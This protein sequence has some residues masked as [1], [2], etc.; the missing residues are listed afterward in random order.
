[1]SRVTPESRLGHYLDGH[2][3]LTGILGVGAYG[4]VY[5]AVDIH[6]FI[7][8]AIKALSKIGLEP[9][10]R[11][12]QHREI[13]L[14][15]KAHRHP[16]IVSL[17]E[18]LHAPDCIYVVMEYCAEGDLFAAITDHGHY[19]G[20]DEL[21]KSVF[22]QLL[23][24]VEFCHSQ[25]IYHRDLKP[26]N[27]LVADN[28][29]RLKLSDFGLATTE[30]WSSDFGCGSTFYMSPECGQSSGSVLST[31]YASAPNDVW[32]LGVILI[33][34]T[35][36]RNPWKRASLADETYRAFLLDPNFLHTILPISPEL[37]PLLRHIF[38]PDP[39][40]RITVPQLR[41]AIKCCTRLTVYE[42][43][44]SATPTPVMDASEWAKMP[45]TPRTPSGDSM[46]EDY[47]YPI[48]DLPQRQASPAVVCPPTPE[49]PLWRARAVGQP[50]GSILA[51][52][53]IPSIARFPPNVPYPPES[54]RQQ[55]Q[56]HHS[57]AINT[58]PSPDQN[59]SCSLPS[60]SFTTPLHPPP[61]CPLPHLPPSSPL[62]QAPVTP[63]SVPR[64]RRK[65]ARESISS[66]AQIQ[67]CNPQQAQTHN[68]DDSERTSR[69]LHQNRVP[70][71]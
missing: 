16:N 62:P 36:G 30:P 11:T 41:A 45:P 47:A 59:Q 29:K 19:V 60:S 42:E 55:L 54:F 20:D 38:H 56:S 24:A 44:V 14:H 53:L 58:Y 43:A 27:V 69:V 39:Q 63:I 1:M 70:V 52:P 4:V 28:G 3:E 18:I 17:V 33:N 35:C 9:A 65:R 67:D 21:V 37:E 71:Y 50:A 46:D 66:I 22:C 40:L 61:K 48:K 26:E 31:A 2:L 15:R 5:T 34:L 7:P 57:V 49:S 8:Y 64:L 25:G 12:F 13:L 23:D 6:T 10:Q 32:S 51:S 68:A